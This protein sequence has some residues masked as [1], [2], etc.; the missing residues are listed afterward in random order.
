MNPAPT[1]VYQTIEKQ[2]AQLDEQAQRKVLSFVHSLNEDGKENIS[3][4]DME[5]LLKD[6]W[7]N[8]EDETV[9]QKYLWK[10]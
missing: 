10:N 5:Y 9:W 1:K 6:V 2:I 8:K 3:F 7:D 4:Q